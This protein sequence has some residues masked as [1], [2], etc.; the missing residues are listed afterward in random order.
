MAL[1]CCSLI[2]APSTCQIEEVN[3]AAGD[4]GSVPPR[5]QH[6]ITASEGKENEV[7]SRTVRSSKG[8]AVGRRLSRLFPGN[9]FGGGSPLT[10]RP[11]EQTNCAFARLA[12][13][14]DSQKRRTAMGSKG[15]VTGQKRLA[16]EADFPVSNFPRSMLRNQ[17]FFP[18]SRVLSSMH[19]D[20]RGVSGTQR[21][22]RLTWHAARGLVR[23]E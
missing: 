18:V 12:H 15:K 2:I 10:A 22:K 7:L 17:P 1:T 20:S 19:R 23:N 11:R 16:P 21:S 8:P 14:A 4:A 6:A 9:L 13:S 3:S 5:A